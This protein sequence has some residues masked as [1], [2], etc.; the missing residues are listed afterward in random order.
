MPPD[1]KAT[2]IAIAAVTMVAAAAASV[3]R[4]GWQRGLR[5]ERRRACMALVPENVGRGEGKRYTIWPSVG[6]GGA[7]GCHPGVGAPGGKPGA[8]GAD[9]SGSRRCVLPGGNR[10]ARG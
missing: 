7:L 1:A 2:M 4:E 8:T 6:R 10:H 9:V 3:S 5:T